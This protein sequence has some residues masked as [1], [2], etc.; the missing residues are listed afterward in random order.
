M[1]WST[2][3]AITGDCNTQYGTGAVPTPNWQQSGLYI[4]DGSIL[5]SMYFSGR[6]NFN[7]GSVKLYVAYYNASTDGVGIDSNIELN[8]TE[9]LPETI[10]A[11]LGNGDLRTASVSLGDFVITG[12]RMLLF[13]MGAVNNSSGAQRNMPLNIHLNYEL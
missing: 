2:S 8:A 11:N 12:N 5:K 4:P 10:I 1:S 9:I 7:F 13:F 3:Q 6:S